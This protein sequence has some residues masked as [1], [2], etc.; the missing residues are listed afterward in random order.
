[1]VLKIIKLLF[2]PLLVFL[3]SYFLF[4]EGLKY[5]ILMFLSL[6]IITYPIYYYGQKM[7]KK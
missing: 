2:G 7:N 4:N 1:M 3:I 5:S 6:I